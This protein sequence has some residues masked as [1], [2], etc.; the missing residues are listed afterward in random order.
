MPPISPDIRYAVAPSTLGFVLAASG[1]RGFCFIALG[2]EPDLLVQA[3]HGPFPD[4]RLVDDEVGLPCALADLVAYL[5]APYLP[6]PW[7]LDIQ[8]TAFQRQV[9]QALCAIPS[10]ATLS[11]AELAQQVGSPKAVRAVAGACA[12]NKLA[13]AIPCH[14]VIGKNGGLSGYRWGLGRK[15]ELLRREQAQGTV[16]V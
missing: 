7:P 3:L 5:E 13:V 12:A 11:Y 10:G 2:D 8:G 1:G 16:S 6:C 9:W 15:A 14:R 4:A